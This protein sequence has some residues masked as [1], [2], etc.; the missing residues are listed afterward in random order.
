MA[1]SREQCEQWSQLAQAFEGS[2]M[3]RQRYC[4]LKQIRIHQLDYWR[5]KL[6]SQNRLPQPSPAH[7]IPLELRDEPASERISG[8]SLRIGRLTI[9]VKRGFD[10][11]LL[12]EVIRVVD[13]SC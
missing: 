11:Q 6:R 10:Q 7:W 3:S 5:K 13:P 12:A 4:E 8:I 2:G 9:E 1:F